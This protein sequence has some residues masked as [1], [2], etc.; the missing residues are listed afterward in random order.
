MHRARAAPAI[1][2]SL[3]TNRRSP[4]LLFTAAFPN[5]FN[6]LILEDALVDL[7]KYIL[8]SYMHKIIFYKALLGIF[9]C[10]QQ[11]QRVLAIP[12]RKNRVA[13]QAVSMV[14]LYR[15]TC[16][17]W[18][19]HSKYSR[20]LFL[21]KIWAQ[22]WRGGSHSG[23]HMHLFFWYRQ[24]ESIYQLVDLGRLRRASKAQL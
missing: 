17:H 2:Q 10:R 20:Q 9:I 24:E 12:S 3:L 4:H 16:S 7:H 14:S 21:P 19:S 1:S 8:P 15:L 13:N 5:H 11:I 6:S 18:C 23:K 22:L